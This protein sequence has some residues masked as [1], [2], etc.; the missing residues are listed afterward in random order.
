MKES[1]N[2][3]ANI[4]AILSL[5]ISF[6]SLYNSYLVRKESNAEYLVDNVRIEHLYPLFVKA[7]HESFIKGEK[8]DLQPYTLLLYNKIR[9]FN[10][11]HNPIII[12]NINCYIDE[13]KGREID[14]YAQLGNIGSM[15]IDAGDYKDISYSVYSIAIEKR[16]DILNRIGNFVNRPKTNKE[17]LV[18]SAAYNDVLISIP[19]VTGYT[20]YIVDEL[21]TDLETPERYLK[22]ETSKDNIL[23]VDIHYPYGKNKYDDS[24]K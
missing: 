9:I 17:H 4:V 23:W 12:K 1:K 15:K 20:E 16:K 7:Q 6:F 24:T 11:S 13:G 18:Q 5:L 21:Y 8:N 22:I 10:N 14:R 19:Y 2:R 3:L